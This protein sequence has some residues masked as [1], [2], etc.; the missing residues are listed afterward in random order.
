MTINDA[1][2]TAIKF[3]PQWIKE[4]KQL[5]IEYYLNDEGIVAKRS[6]KELLEYKNNITDINIKNYIDEIIIEQKNNIIED[7]RKR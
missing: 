5:Q 2:E 3:N 6:I 7:K 1:F 4:N